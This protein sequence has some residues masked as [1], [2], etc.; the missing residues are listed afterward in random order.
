MFWAGRPA[1]TPRRARIYGDRIDDWD[2][3]HVGPDW[4]GGPGLRQDDQARAGI[5]AEARPADDAAGDRQLHPGQATGSAIAG[6]PGGG[7]L[8][9][10]GADGSRVPA[11]RLGGPY[12]GYGAEPRPDEHRRGRC[13][14]WLRTERERR[15]FVY[16]GVS[17]A[18]KEEN[19]KRAGR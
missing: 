10:G 18:A 1:G 5:R 8:L 13:A 19:E 14:F 11:E 17:E 9:A 15:D 4:D 7:A 12:R 2:D 16:D 6:R 3:D